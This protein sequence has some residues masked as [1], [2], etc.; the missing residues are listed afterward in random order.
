[1]SESHT[2]DQPK[3][4]LSIKRESFWQLWRK[5]GLLMVALLLLIIPLYGTFSP[6]FEFILFAVSL[7]ALTYPVFFRPIEHLGKSFYPRWITGDVQS[8]VLSWPHS[9]CY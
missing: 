1:M 3:D 7:A 6:L 5:R 8:F 9:H 4:L 2:K